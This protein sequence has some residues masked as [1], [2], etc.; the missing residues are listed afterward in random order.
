MKS[1]KIPSVDA[2]DL[3]LAKRNQEKKEYTLLNKD[4]K[5]NYSRYINV[6][7]YSLDLIE[8]KKIASEVYDNKKDK[9]VFK[10]E[11]EDRFELSNKVINV[12]F[13]YAC[14][15]FNKLRKNTYVKIGYD[16]RQMDF[17][18][19]IATIPKTNTIIG[20]VVIFL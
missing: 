13:K 2:K 15:E 19:C 1:I 16:V 10:I 20:V 3:F 8:I 17:V 5:A 9:F 12:T 4:G 14:K 18:D 7:D 11:P 6:L